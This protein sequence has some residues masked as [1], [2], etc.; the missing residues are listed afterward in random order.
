MA[1]TYSEQRR[2]QS[3]TEIFF[4]WIIWRLRNSVETSLAPFLIV[5][6]LLNVPKKCRIFDLRSYVLNKGSTHLTRL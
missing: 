5:R 1:K 2:N 4:G 3:I 6:E